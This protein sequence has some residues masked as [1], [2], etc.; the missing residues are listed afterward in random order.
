MNPSLLSLALLLFQRTHAD[1]LEKEDVFNDHNPPAPF[2]Q[3]DL[4]NANACNQILRELPDGCTCAS[5]SAAGTFLATCSRFCQ[6]C[7]SPQQICV[8]Y[9][10]KFEYRRNN[11]NLQY[12]P[13]SIEYQASYTG[14][15]SAKVGFSYKTNYDTSFNAQTCTS[16]IDGKN[17]ICEVDQSA[18]CVGE[19]RHNCARAGVTSGVFEACR[20][21]SPSQLA[22]NS[23]FLAFTRAE[24]RIE[25]CGL[26]I[27]PD[28]R[29][30]I[31]PKKSLPDRNKDLLKLSI[32][33]D[34]LRGSLTRK[35][36]VRGSR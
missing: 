11:A 21:G 17:C 13:R 30:V 4:Q 12:I 3:R 18:S 31:P 23:P 7:M 6:R 20:R 15:D 1:L 32:P 8:T 25:T 10:L 14:R 16:S 28:P 36:R 35:M 19:L 34:G 9:S 5:S 33:A 26:D 22:L 2:D 27:I 29:T 24:L